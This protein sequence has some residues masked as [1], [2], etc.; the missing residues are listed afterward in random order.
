VVFSPHLYADSITVDRALLGRG[1]IGVDQGFALASLAAAE[2]GT[3]AWVGEW[4]W[5]GD[6]AEDSSLIAEYARQE[7]AHLWGGAWWQ[8]KQACGDPHDFADGA[9]TTPTPVSGNINRFACPSGAP[10]GTPE[11]TARI[12][13]RPYP[14]AAPGTLSS[15]RSNPGG[16]SFSLRGSDP[17]ASGSCVLEVWIPARGADPP[18]LEG[19]GVTALATRPYAGGWL[20]SGCARGDYSLHGEY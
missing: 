14:R 9:D 13:S 1:L 16:A 15:L 6:P 18:A 3:T 12:L 17:D 2:Y 11:T 4:G 10:I 19:R 5:F 20:A 7:D 8:W